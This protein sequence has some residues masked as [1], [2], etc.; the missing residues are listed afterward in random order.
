MV[1]GFADSTKLDFPFFLLI[2][3]II[4]INFIDLI[5]FLYIEL[6][7]DIVE[8]FNSVSNGRGLYE[9]IETTRI[10]KDI[11]KP[12]GVLLPMTQTIEG[13]SAI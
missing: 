8:L 9:K 7:R 6:K 2:N 11:F 10:F 13:L 12:Y 3:R 4:K 5:K 1:C